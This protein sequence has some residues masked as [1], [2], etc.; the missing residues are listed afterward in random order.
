MQSYD[1]YKLGQNL[2]RNYLPFQSESNPNISFLLTI[3]PL[4]FI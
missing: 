3:V 2:T 1:S 4:N